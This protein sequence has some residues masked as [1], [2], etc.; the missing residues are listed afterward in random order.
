MWL[1][2]TCRPVVH[3]SAVL[4]SGPCFGA[5]IMRRSLRLK[6]LSNAPWQLDGIVDIYG[7]YLCV[8]VSL[9]GSTANLPE[10][11][12]PCRTQNFGRNYLGL[13]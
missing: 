12:H 5:I 4:A 3:A 9:E 2:R 13:F 10:N 6:I 11:S 8:L 7:K 1:Y